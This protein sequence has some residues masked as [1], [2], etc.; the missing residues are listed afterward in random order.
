MTVGETVNFYGSLAALAGCLL[1]IGAYT[2]MPYITGR[3]RWWSS[4]IGRLLVTKAVAISGLMVIVIV[5]YLTDIDAEWIRAVRG[6]FCGVI[7]VMMVYQATLV[8]RIMS[9]REDERQ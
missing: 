7:G 2:V 6:V 8:V 5:F 1:F 9:E 4:H 3:A